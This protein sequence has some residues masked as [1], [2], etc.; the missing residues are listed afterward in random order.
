MYNEKSK[1]F[2]KT[3]AIVV[4]SV[5]AFLMVGLANATNIG[6]PQWFMDQY[7]V[8]NYEPSAEIAALVD[9]SGMNELGE[10]YFYSGQP[11][12]D[13]AEQFNINCAELLNEESN[14]LG[15]YNGRI[16]LFDVTDQR[17]AG[18]KNV[19]A[20]H[21][22]LHAAYDR[23]SIF[24]KN[25]VNELI[26]KEL[27][28]TQDQNVLELVELYADLEP[29]Q[30]IN[31]LHSIFGTES[32]NLSTELEEYYRK[33]FSD[34]G[35][36]ISENSKYKAV[37]DDMKSQ[38]EMVEEK[39]RVL[40]SEIDILQKQYF[41]DAEKLNRDIDD[42]NSR[43]DSGYGFGSEAIFN[44]ERNNLIYRQGALKAQLDLLN[45]RI[46]EYNGYVEELRA[47][48]KA[49]NALSSELNSQSQVVD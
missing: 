37:F 20:A 10:F 6:T 36:V 14:V 12:L 28:Q 27:S 35:K 38:A 11:S 13:G 29:G 1:S 42:F 7:V 17:I 18:I 24:D 15:C 39:M 43:A 16:Y 48:G 46:D 45:T 3:L 41:V 21:E 26:E 2:S 40:N 19:T 9:G 22:M 30:E 8:R 33:Y 49:V 47:L 31:E 34:R 25:Y 32:A 23:L 4:L 44:A 5:S